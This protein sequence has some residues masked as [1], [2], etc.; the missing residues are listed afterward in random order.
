[1]QWLSQNWIWVLFFV[2]MI[3]N[4]QAKIASNV[5]PHLSPVI[6]I[7]YSRLQCRLE[8]TSC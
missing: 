5:R 8:V 7:D 4:R 3:L 2:A 6:N 1:M